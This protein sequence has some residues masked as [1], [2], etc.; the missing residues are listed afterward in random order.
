M[1]RLKIHIHNTIYAHSQPHATWRRSPTRYSQRTLWPYARI[2]YGLAKSGPQFLFERFLV[3]GP[4]LYEHSCSGRPTFS[5]ISQFFVIFEI[6]MVANVFCHFCP[7]STKTANMVRLQIPLAA[8]GL[9]LLW[10]L[11]IPPGVDFTDLGNCTC[12]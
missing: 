7:A 9:I 2:S 3:S 6:Y 12:D 8:S 11:Y 10:N 1:L 5:T 4:I